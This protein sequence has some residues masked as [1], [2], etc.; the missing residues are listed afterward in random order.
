[1][2]KPL[3]SVLVRLVLAAVMALSGLLPAEA[4][5]TRRK[6]EAPRLIRDAEIEGLMRLYAKP[7]FKAAGINPNA[8]K[9]YLINDRRVN[10]FV[11]GGQRI[12]INSGTIV[13]ARTP[14]EVIGILAHET[15]HI[16]GGHLARMG[17]EMERASTQNIIGMLLGAA[18]MVGGAAAGSSGA[19]KAGQGILMGSQGF[20]QRSILSYQREMESAADQAALKYL[21]ATGQSPKGMLDM[22]QRLANASIATAAN[23]D[24]YLLSHPMPLERIRNLESDA[25]RSPNFDR[26]DDQALVLRHRLA[27]A[28]LT[29]FIESAQVVYQKY[30]SS[31]TSL[32]ARYARA[33]AMYRRGDMKNALP[34][35]EGLIRDL[36]Q[37]PYFWE[38]KGQALLESGRSGEALAPL[39]KAR[40]L[41]PN[42]GLIQILAAQ[43]HLDRGKS[44]DA[45]QALKL[46]VLA[47]KTESDMPAIYKFMAQAYGQKNDVA[48]AELATAQYA[49]MTGDRKLAVE[50]AKALQNHFKH[51]SPEW[52]QAND[53]VTFAAKK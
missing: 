31:D 29:G 42:N 14:N 25:D 12:F 30:P 40:E 4:Q 46:L 51:G 11:A 10:A 49:F 33:I 23:V 45:D 20:A 8:V 48:R 3:F 24:P 17:I 18:A 50:K 5:S 38:L 35:M 15:G 52:L 27:Q 36:P 22:F 34:V 39:A 53:I 1:M 37:D 19:A 2:K 7:V 32:P 9:V 26:R 41:L 28:K 47:R 43:A 21:N 16:A 6:A 44:G 13:Q